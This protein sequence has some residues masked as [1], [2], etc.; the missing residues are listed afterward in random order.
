MNYSVVTLSNDSRISLKL[1][2]LKMEDKDLEIKM[3][4]D[5]GLVPEGGSNGTPEVIE[6]NIFVPSPYNLTVNDVSA[7]HDGSGGIVYVRT[8]QQIQMANLA[9]SIKFNPAVKFTVEQTDDGFSISSDEFNA[10]KSY[11]ITLLKGMRGRIGG[12]L[13]EQFD[14]NV[15]F[16]ELEPGVSFTNKKGMY[17]SS[18]GNKNIEVRITNVPKVKVTISKIY[19]SNILMAQ[20]YG[21]YPQNRGGYSE[22]NDYYYADYSNNLTMGDII[23]EKEIETRSLQKYGNSRLFNFNIEDRLPDF[24]GIYH[25]MIRSATDYWVNDSRL[26]SKSDLGLIAKEGNGK[27]IVFA[28]S[29]QTAQAV[30]GVNIVAIRKQ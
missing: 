24:K 17:L 13:R 19:E 10:D 16:G 20:R 22:E 25:I 9:A 4:L 3:A 28:N 12:T 5:K 11:A 8:S 7:E 2:N 15:A 1:Q 29:I 21:Y 14:G 23:Y 18:K 30:N 26:I 6:N 27:I